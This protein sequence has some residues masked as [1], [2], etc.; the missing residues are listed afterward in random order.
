MC[1]HVMPVEFALS[2]NI[3]QNKWTQEEGDDGSGSVGHPRCAFAARGEALLGER[4][5]LAS[6]WI[7]S[8]SPSLGTEVPETLN[9]L[10]FTHFIRKRSFKIQ[11]RSCALSAVTQGNESLPDDGEKSARFDNL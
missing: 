1:V 4:S 5:L 7:R 8:S 11:L 10:C 2:L 6:P 3:S 9:Q